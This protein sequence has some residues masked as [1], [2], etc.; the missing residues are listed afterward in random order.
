[1]TQSSFSSVMQLL[2]QGHFTAQSQLSTTLIDKAFENFVGKGENA[3][4]QHFLLFQQ[5]F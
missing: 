4:N 3:G 2:A 5:C 1:M